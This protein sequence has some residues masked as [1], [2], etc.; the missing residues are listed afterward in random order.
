MSLQHLVYGLAHKFN[1]GLVALAA[2]MNKN[3]RVLNMKVNPNNDTHHLTI[4]ELETIA[5]F[6]NGNLKVAEYFAHKE[7]AVVYVMPD[8][9]HMDEQALL[10]SFLNINSKLGSLS[11]ELMHD[12]SDGS[13]NNHELK[14]LIKKIH[15]V[16][17]T[18]LIHKATL[19]RISQ[20][21]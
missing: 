12:Y 1:G 15:E 4:E 17:V 7:N 20:H 18:L 3:D 6:T 2:T 10:D 13:I 5:D 19:Q 21:A 8:I 14:S 11:T 9:E 16:E